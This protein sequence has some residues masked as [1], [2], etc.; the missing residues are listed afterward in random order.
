MLHALTRFL[1][2]LRSVRDRPEFA[3]HQAE[4]DELLA[5]GETLRSLVREYIDIKRGKKRRKKDGPPDLV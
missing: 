4:I 5:F 2:I 1:S 3:P